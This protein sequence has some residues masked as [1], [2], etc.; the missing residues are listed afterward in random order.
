MLTVW[1]LSLIYLYIITVICFNVLYTIYIRYNLVNNCRIDTFF[2][3]I[4]NHSTKALR[5]P[6]K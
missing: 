5:N 4:L 2:S 1:S 3:L 6:T